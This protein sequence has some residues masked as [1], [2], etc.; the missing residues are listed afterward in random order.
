MELENALKECNGSSPGPDLIHYEM[1]KQMDGKQKEV[2]LDLYNNIY[3]SGT[4][5][6]NWKKALL[7]PIPK[8]GKDPKNPANYR[9]ISLTNCCCKVLE[10]MVS[11][12]LMWILEKNDFNFPIR[13]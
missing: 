5:P 4:F 2:L 1:L 12:R 3:L 7:I 10:R 8:P 11:K 6:D 9:P 13:L